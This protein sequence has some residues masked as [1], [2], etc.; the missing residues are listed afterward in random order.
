[1]LLTITTTHRPATDLGYVL[2]KNPA[3]CQEFEVS[4]GKV[5][6]FYPEVTH[7]IDTGGQGRWAAAA[8]A[9]LVSLWPAFAAEAAD[10]TPIRWDVESL[11]RVVKRILCRRCHRRLE[12]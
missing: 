7:M 12:Y 9:C 2:H 1:M 4:F 8:L 5:H 6:V 3:Q 11:A 10:E